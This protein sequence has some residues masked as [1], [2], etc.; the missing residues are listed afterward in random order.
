MLVDVS[1]EF[2]AGAVS[3][4]TGP[5]GPGPSTLLR[6]INGLE[7]ADS[8]VV[9]LDGLDVTRL[10]SAA[11]CRRVGWFSPTLFPHRSAVDNVAFAVR[12][13]RRRRRSSTARS[14]H[15][16]RSLGFAS[17]FGSLPGRL[18]VAD[19]V[20]VALA[21]SLVAETDV[22][23]LD[24]PFAGLDPALSSELRG[25]FLDVATQRSLTL[26]L[27][28]T[29]TSRLMERVQFV[30]VL[31]H[32]GRVLQTGSPDAVFARPVDR[33]VSALF[34]DARGLRRLS[35]LPLDEVAVD[36]LPILALGASSADA[37]ELATRAGRWLLI[38][39][40]GRPVGWLDASRLGTGPLTEVPIVSP[41]STVTNGDTLLAVLDGIVTSPSRMVV[42][43]D[44]DGHIV[45]VIGMPALDPHLPVN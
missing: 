14:E 12:H 35:L 25:T 34:G 2:P 27:A 7:Q 17:S 4:V 45:G 31:G 1:V 18:P 24:N 19:K 30:V 41:Q 5:T 9:E 13:S 15:L 40:G 11:L 21:R 39:D 42:K 37:R 22:V 36:S 6:L 16:L 44:S 28:D 32:G 29:A 43:V 20:R 26:V 33:E 10:R 3:V 23:L 8:G 38:S